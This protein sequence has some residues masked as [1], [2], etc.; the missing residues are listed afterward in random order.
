MLMRAKTDSMYHSDRQNL[1]TADSFHGFPKSKPS[2]PFIIPSLRLPIPPNPISGRLTLS[3]L[4]STP[5][6]IYLSL[7]YFRYFARTRHLLDKVMLKDL[8]ILLIVYIF[9]GIFMKSTSKEGI[10][11]SGKSEI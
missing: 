2:T 11:N 4:I 9:Q 3:M 6:K 10:L 8:V 1:S 7:L 5:V